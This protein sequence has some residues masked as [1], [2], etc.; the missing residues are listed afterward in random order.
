MPL[1]VSRTTA[2]QGGRLVPV[3]TQRPGLTWRPAGS[4]RPA[5]KP[6]VRVFSPIV[7]PFP[8]KKRIRSPRAALNATC[9]NNEWMGKRFQPAHNVFSCDS[10]FHHVSGYGARC[11]TN[12]KSEKCACSLRLPWEQRPPGERLPVKILPE[13]LPIACQPKTRTRT[14][15][16]QQ[17]PLPTEPQPASNTGRGRCPH[18][19]FAPHGFHHPSL[20]VAIRS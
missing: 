9:V 17:D 13:P 6:V 4:L 15:F 1:T 8:R 2:F 20:P 12:V 5:H 16:G 7:D 18:T 19:S 11:S 3:S 10:P 14:T